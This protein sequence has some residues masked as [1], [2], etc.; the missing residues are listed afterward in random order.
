[1]FANYLFASIV[2]CKQRLVYWSWY[3]NVPDMYQR[4]GF[5]FDLILS[6]SFFLCLQM[7]TVCEYCLRIVCE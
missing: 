2:L 5:A 1:M 6:W 7:S 4:L 3:T